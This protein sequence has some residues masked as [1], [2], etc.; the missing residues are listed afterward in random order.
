[1]ESSLRVRLLLL[2]GTAILA[3]TM[4]QF[5]TSFR[6]AMKEANKLFDYHMQQIAVALKDN[7]FDHGFDWYALPEDQ[8][9]SFDL[10]VQVWNDKGERIYQSRPYPDLSGHGALGY[11]TVALGRED[12]RLYVVQSQT[13]F[14]Q[15]AQKMEIRRDRAVQLALHAVWPI[16]PVSLLL[17]LAAWW[18]V[19]SALSPLRRVARKLG[20][21]SADDVGPVFVDDLPRE[22]SPLVSELNSLLSRTGREIQVQQRFLADAAHELRSP[23]TALKLQVQTLARAKDETGRELA[24]QRLHGGVDRAA[25]LVEQLLSLAR[26]DRQSRE[27]PT[28]VTPLAICVEMAVAD[29]RSFASAR[30]IRLICEDI[31]QVDVL[32][33]PDSLAIMVRNLLDNAIRYTP[34]EGE[35]RVSIEESANSICLI[36]EDSGPG[37]PEADRER[38]FDR[39]FRV[40]GSGTSG[41]GLGLAIVKAIVDHHKA[42]IL[43]SKSELGGLLVKVVFPLKPGQQ[44]VVEGA[45]TNDQLFRVN[46][47]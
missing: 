24:I 26:Q 19:T 22:V 42:F 18:V 10:V 27:Y 44:S 15:I 8:N 34:E 14:V 38:V 17:F 37:I 23:L 12:W 5:I 6:A 35:I 33:D 21:R 43:L 32:G 30:R 4:L 9:E 46:R 1:M 31:P 28:T 41:S 45:G 39:F 40:P 29:V 7:R 16:V 25:R 13:Q 47:N 2:L 36:V 11:S 20:N 3:A